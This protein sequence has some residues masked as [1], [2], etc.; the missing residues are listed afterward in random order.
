MKNLALLY[1][2][3]LKN[4]QKAYDFATKAREAF[5]DD[6]E[7]AKTLGVLSYRRKEY[8]RSAQLLEQSVRQRADDAEIFY[9]LGMARYRLNQR[10][11]SKEKLQ[12]ALALNSAAEFAEE[13]KRILQELK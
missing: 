6:P 1:F 13:A 9:F 4:D 2:G 11:Q 12:R 8:S 5:P 10:I 3:K 7:I